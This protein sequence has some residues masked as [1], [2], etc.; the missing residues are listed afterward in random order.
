[1]DLLGTVVASESAESVLG[2]ALMPNDAGAVIVTR[3]HHV[4]IQNV[5]A[6]DETKR[7]KKK[8]KKK[9]SQLS[10]LTCFFFFFLKVNDRTATCSW[11]VSPKSQ[12]SLPC[13]LHERSLS[14]SSTSSSSTALLLT[15]VG[16]RATTVVAWKADDTE[17]KFV[18]RVEVSEPVFA[19][20]PVA[21]SLDTIVVF[22]SG[23]VAV[24]DAHFQLSHGTIERDAPPHWSRL[25][26]DQAGRVLLTLHRA[27]DLVRLSVFAVRARDADDSGPAAAAGSVSVELMCE[28]TFSSALPIVSFAFELEQRTMAF[29]TAAGACFIYRFSSVAALLR[30]SATTLELTDLVG[31]PRFVH[32]WQVACYDVDA[33][34]PPTAAAAAAAAAATAG[35]TTTPPS[36]RRSRRNKREKLS[37]SGATQAPIAESGASVAPIQAALINPTALLLIGKAKDE[38]HCL[39]SL[40]S[41]EYGA[42]LLSS[43]VASAVNEKGVTAPMISNTRRSVVALVDVGLARDADEQPDDGHVLHCSILSSRIRLVDMLMSAERTTAAVVEHEKRAWSGAPPVVDLTAML[44]AAVEHKSYRLEHL[45]SDKQ[46]AA[47]EQTLLGRLRAA[48]DEAAA[49]RVCQELLANAPSPQGC[50][51]VS[52]E[53]ALLAASVCIENRWRKPL[54]CVVRTRALSA[55][56]CDGVLA[57]ALDDEQEHEKARLDLLAACLECQA[58]IGGRD[59]VRLLKFALAATPSQALVERVLGGARASPAEAIGWFVDRILLIDVD[60]AALHRHLVALDAY[61]C[62]RL[63]SHLRRRLTCL[64]ATLGDDALSMQRLAATSAATAMALDVDAATETHERT[65][66][67]RQRARAPSVLAS[68]VLPLDTA[69]L[70]LEALLDARAHTLARRS[71]AVEELQRV[72]QGAAARAGHLRRAGAGQGLSV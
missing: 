53:T 17:M 35:A 30:A 55:A 52:S 11:S 3:K 28:H 50:V 8:K 13:V 36:A 25:V 56:A 67:K 40:W 14:S 7:K 23:S 2:V 68:R 37:S 47:H 43:I 20:F 29:V 1:M 54:A 59:V 63:L 6:I 26:Q 22:E 66:A 21:N 69:I 10:V 46:H 18:H 64:S 51:A 70:W 31:E 16:A 45:A 61:T 39:L 65:P 48:R 71:Q 60:R 57:L 5:N 62:E 33:P 15:C 9:K 41:T 38:S 4:A 42:L 27:N 44:G 72:Q 24:L 49:L 58:D 32:S 19:L 34:P 12:I